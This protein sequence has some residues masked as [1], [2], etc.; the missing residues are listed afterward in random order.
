MEVVASPP[1]DRPWISA[2]QGEQD[3]GCDAQRLVARQQ[4]DQ[5]GRHR[6]GADREGEGGGAA[7]A[8]ADMADHHARPAA[9]S[10]TAQ[11]EGRA[12]QHRATGL[13]VGKNTRPIVAAK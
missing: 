11:R 8:V 10:E 3:R 4:A 9:A 1:T 2:Q 6:H 13:C 7:A 5:E 12:A